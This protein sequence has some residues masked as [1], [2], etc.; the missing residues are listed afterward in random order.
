M[1]LLQFVAIPLLL[2]GS[3]NSAG[4]MVVATK[5]QNQGKI[6]VVQNSEFQVLL[7]ANPT[8]GYQWQIV[9]YDSAIIKFSKEEFLTIIND[10]R[11]GAPGRQMFKFKAIHAGS[12]DLEMIYRRS[13]ERAAPDAE[14]FRVQVTV[15]K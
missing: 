7:D 11:M 3:F 6:R 14:R 15:A 4:K 13:W 9:S 10:G 1:H 8:T 12:T 2:L 5:E